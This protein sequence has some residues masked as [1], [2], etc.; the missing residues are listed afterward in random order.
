MNSSEIIG[1][2]KD[3]LSRIVNSVSLD[4]AKQYANR[5]LQQVQEYI[6]DGEKALDKWLVR[7]AKSSWSLPIAVGFGIALLVIGDVLQV[8]H[9][10]FS[11]LKLIF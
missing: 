7:W 6:N 9:L 2:V 4:E 1:K 11:L 5:S 3:E 8:A 10:A